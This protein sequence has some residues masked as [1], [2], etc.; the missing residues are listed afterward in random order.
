MCVVGCISEYNFVWIYNSLFRIYLHN[1]IEI[2]DF[3]TKH[4]FVS[5]H[6]YREAIFLECI[7]TL[8]CITCASN[9][10]DHF[11]SLITSTDV[12]LRVIFICWSTY[13]KMWTH[14]AAF[15]SW[16]ITQ[17]IA[18]IA[19]SFSGK[20]SQYTDSISLRPR[21]ICRHFAGDI[22]KRLFLNENIRVS[23]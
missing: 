8:E 15:A 23:L 11:E 1:A 14:R 2:R 21:P 17:C 13:L 10:V 6:V 16:K 19:R 9:P 22:L 7:P 5:K 3:D 18:V 4:S 12:S 20:S